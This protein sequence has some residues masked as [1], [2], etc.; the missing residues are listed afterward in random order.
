MNEVSLTEALKRLSPD[1]VNRES[2]EM[3]GM[4][5]KAE[6]CPRQAWEE[7]TRRGSAYDPAECAALWPTFFPE[8]TRIPMVINGRLPDRSTVLEMVRVMCPSGQPVGDQAPG[9]TPKAPETPTPDPLSDRA[10]GAWAEAPGAATTVPVAEAATVPVAEATTVPAVKAATVPM[11]EAVIVPEAEATT[12]PAVK[13]ATV[14]AGEAADGAAGHELPPPEK[15]S[16]AILPEPNLYRDGL[17]LPVPLN[18]CKNAP[19]RLPDEL[20]RGVLRRGH[21]L[22]LSGSSKAGKSFL[23]MELCVAIA[24]GREWLG[25][26]CRQGRVLY[27]NLEIDHASVFHRFFSI[28]RAMGIP[29]ENAWRISVWNLRGRAMTM[30]LLARPLIERLLSGMFDAVIIDPIYKVLPG[31]ENSATETAAFCNVLDAVCEESGCAV[32]FCHHHSKGDQSG[33]RVADRASGSGVFARDPDALLDII[34][35]Q[36]EERQR[37]AAKK[38]ATA[39]RM[40]SC[41][42]EFP[43]FGP[44]DFWF[45]YPV[46]RVDEDGALADALPPKRPKS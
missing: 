27:V 43:P 19:P 30:E 45:E 15:A 21:K 38:G 6:G 12:V 32:I 20:I 3:T 11:A 17:P 39:W 8:G 31:D 24:E 41:L 29:M 10:P 34:E 25:F 1:A 22:L 28:Y 9:A 35:L 7:W 33:K 46:H 40:E 2:W 23:L 44:V 16:A 4:V 13:P 18:L 36:P 42:R 14:P 5:L 26:P 37:R